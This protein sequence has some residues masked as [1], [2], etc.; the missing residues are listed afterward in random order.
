MAS[1]LGISAVQFMEPLTRGNSIDLWPISKFVGMA[2]SPKRLDPLVPVDVVP[3]V[4]TVMVNVLAALGHEGYQA[5]AHTAPGRERRKHNECQC[6]KRSFCICLLAVSQDSSTTLA[7][8]RIHLKMN[9]EVGSWAV[10]GKATIEST[11][12]IMLFLPPSPS[13]CGYGIPNV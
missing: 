13:L 2:S 3:A 12:L 10:P 6:K 11:T 8:K 4:W 5:T 7:S 9:E 1:A